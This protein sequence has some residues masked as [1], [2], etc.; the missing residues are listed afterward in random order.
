MRISGGERTGDHR[1]ATTRRLL[2]FHRLRRTDFDCRTAGGCH[3]S[4][5]I[6]DLGG[7]RQKRLLDVRRRLCRRLEKWY[8]ELVG[9]FLGR[10]M[11]DSS[12][13]AQITLVADEQLVHV[14]AC[15]SI[16][17][18]Q[19]LFDIVERFL[20][21]DVVDDDDAMRSPVV[22]RSNRP[23]TLLTRRVPYLQFDCFAVQL[24]CSNFKIDANCR[25]IRFRI[26]VVGKSQQ[27][28]RL[29]DTGIADKQELDQKVVVCACHS[30]TLRV[31]GG[32]SGRVSK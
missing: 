28:T 20:V 10:V 3:R 19:P 24:N 13:R 1:S 17:L 4:H 6:L 5:S 30:E 14:L 21:G 12:L 18:L 32:A 31:V 27:Q 26:G 7:H 2:V 22:T 9:V 23:K 8:A 11:L 25:N 16:D 29:S 15:I